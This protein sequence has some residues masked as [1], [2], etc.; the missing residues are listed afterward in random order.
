MVRRRMTRTGITRITVGV[1]GISIAWLM[2]GCSG[3]ATVKP[4]GAAQSVVDVVSGQTGF[5]PTDVKCPS[6]VKAQVGADFDCHFTG[7]EGKPYIAHMRIVKVDGPR[8][9]FDVKSRP[10]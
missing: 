3:T 1:L 2:T 7:P 6:G 10:S 5:Q 8:V 9:D 4:E